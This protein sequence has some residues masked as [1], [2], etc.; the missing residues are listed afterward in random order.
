MCD[1]ILKRGKNAGT[2]CG[3]KLWGEDGKCRKHSE[4]DEPVGGGLGDFIQQE[5]VEINE[6][7]IRKSV[8]GLT[9]NSNRTLDSMSEDDKQKIKRL[10]EYLFDQ[11]KI[12]DLVIPREGAR[13]FRENP[14][15]LVETNC[16]YRYEVGGKQSRLHVHAF[17][18]IDHRTVV[19]INLTKLKALFREYFGQSW[20]IH[21]TVK[22]AIDSSAYVHY[23]GKDITN[24]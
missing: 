4:F 16:G 10:M 11:E 13:C 18:E 21:C 12:Y 5:P 1:H 23:M 7:R 20:Y 19:H 24:M 17:V 9:M 6:D 2:P 14:E 22:K 3:K 15:L 8:F